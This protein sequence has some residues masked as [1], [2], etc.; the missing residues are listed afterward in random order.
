ME[1]PKSVKHMSR[2]TAGLIH[3][4]ISAIIA[5]V[6]LVLILGV[7]YPPPFFG[8]SRAQTL[9]FLI[10][11]IDL[12]LGPLLTL[13]VFD[14]RKKWLKLDL[15]VIALLQVAGLVY[16]LNAVFQSRPAF[17]VAE[18]EWI[19][20]VY[21]HAVNTD[22][23]ENAHYPRLPLW[24]PK[25]VSLQIPDDP[26]WQSRS[27]ELLLSGGGELRERLAAYA[28]FERVQPFLLSNARPASELQGRLPNTGRA[29][30]D[31]RYV[32]VYCRSGT[33]HML[34]DAKTG[35]PLGATAAAPAP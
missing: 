25:L 20:A 2:W 31:M 33:V 30:E 18:H 27:I 24:G 15:A 21:A 13:I 28:P 26:A 6:V 9:V 32:P 19:T 5:V 12:V 34:L 22:G 4:G 1:N 14:T 23:A 3:L 29:V 35:E 8:V 16:G 17:L 10:I 7:W 11:G